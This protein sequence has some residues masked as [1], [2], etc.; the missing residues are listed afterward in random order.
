MRLAG[1]PAA[2]RADDP[3]AEVTMSSTVE[4]TTQTM[5]RLLSLVGDCLTS[6]VAERLVALRADPDVQS[7]LDYLA[8]RA[9]EGELTEPERLEYDAGVRTLTFIS[10]LQSTARR[11]LRN[12]RK[13]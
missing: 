7:R 10:I 4:A 2:N 6:E 9:N 12:G 13:P 5:E 11:L 1:G 3:D 8:E